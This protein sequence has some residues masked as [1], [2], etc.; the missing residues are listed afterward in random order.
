MLRLQRLAQPPDAAA[1]LAVLPEQS[2]VIGRETLE[3]TGPTVEITYGHDLTEAEYAVEVSY[4]GSY[5]LDEDTLKDGSVL[6]LHFG[7]MGGW[8]ASTLV[9][10]GDLKFEFLP[11]DPDEEES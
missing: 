5:E 6:D 4:E 9:K 11:P 8:I 1:V 2:P 3:R 7:A 10:L